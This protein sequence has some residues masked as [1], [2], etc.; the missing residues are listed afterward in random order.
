MRILDPNWAAAF[1]LAAAVAHQ[2]PLPL[3]AIAGVHKLPEE[4]PP[5]YI[6]FEH[7]R[8][9]GSSPCQAKGVE[10]SPYRREPSTNPTAVKDPHVRIP[11]PSAPF[12]TR[13]PRSLSPGALRG[14]LLWA[15]LAALARHL[16]A[17]SLHRR[18]LPN[19][20]RVIRTR[21]NGR[22]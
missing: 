13:K 19:L 18:S 5:L 2:F 21:I 4:P 12:W 15:R 9:I 1:A 3:T 20:I 14:E 7:Q 22:D 17:R 10:K 16:L 8:H 11:L 6:K